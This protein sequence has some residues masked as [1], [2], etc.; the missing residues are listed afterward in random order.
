[1]GFLATVKEFL[2]SVV[3]GAE[4]PEVKADRGGDDTITGYHFQPP[5]T[6]AQPLPGDV[7]YL[8]DDQGA[9]NAQALGYQDPANVGLAGP[10]EHRLYARAED[11][12]VV[13]QL[14]LKA[15]GTVV[16]SNDAATVEL[17]ADGSLTAQND[18]VQLA[19]GADGLV[20]VTNG[21]ASLELAAAGDVAITTPQASAPLGAD[22]T[23]SLSNSLGGIEV[24]A[25]GNVTATTPLGTFGAGT[26]THASPFGPTGPPL[27]GT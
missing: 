1:V 23:V 20:S 21:Q 8:G 6:D 22:G 25:A 11:G 18:T 3:D 9:G 7:V 15:D 19:V 14:W 24:D 10:G 26:H 17:A 16:L 27:P 2:R 12:T 13:A 5:G 4:A